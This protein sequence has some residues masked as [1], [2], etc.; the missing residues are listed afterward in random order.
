[1]SCNNSGCVSSSSLFKPTQKIIKFY[2]DSL[3]AVEGPKQVAK[4]DFCGLKIPYEYI[5]V[6]K[7]ILPKEVMSM[8][9]QH[10]LGNKL[11]FIALKLTYQPVVN[12]PQTSNCGCGCTS[13]GGVT[14]DQIIQYYFED[15]PDV[16]RHANNILILSGT[17]LNPLVPIYISNPGTKYNVMV[18]ILASAHEIDYNTLTHVDQSQFAFENM[19]WTDIISDTQSKDL[20]IYQGADPV[21]Y[22]STSKISNIELNSRVLIVDD[23]GAGAVYL[24]FADEFNAQQ[25]YSLIS[26]VLQN[27]AVN[28]I[29]SGMQAD[30]TAPVVTYKPFT[31]ELVLGDYPEDS[32]FLI[33]K[34]DLISIMIDSCYDS[35]DGAITVGEYN[36]NIMPVNTTTKYS[37]ISNMGKYNI[38]V[39]VSDNAGNISVESFLFNIK[40]T[41]PAK[42][43]LNEF[44][45]DIVQNV[46][47]YSDGTSGVADTQNKIWL[48]DYPHNKLT[49]QNVIDLLLA[50]VTD[51]RDGLIP[52]NINN[53]N[54]SITAHNSNVIYNEI[55]AEGVYDIYFNVTDA[56]NNSATALW[57][58]T[59]TQA[60]NPYGYAPLDY[61]R[62]EI[63]NNQAPE[64]VFKSFGVLGLYDYTSTGT[65]NKTEIIDFTV[66]HI[67]DD[68]DGNTTV[69][70]QSPKF[71]VAIFK[72][73]EVSSGT[74]GGYTSITPVE[75][76]YIAEPG[77][78]Q[79]QYT[80][81]DNDGAV[82]VETTNV[83][84]Q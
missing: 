23:F 34:S 75:V 58:N 45:I 17:K 66:D 44:G 35:R 70:S 49:K 47:P 51:A 69:S 16:V 72:T 11:T 40:D 18:D 33:E 9:V 84:V 31:P 3:V 52:M 46:M 54:V 13:C 67:T 83:T 61:V 53:I 65:I 12:N 80:M 10:N 38:I 21:G 19:K 73:S 81:I 50:A 24:T 7:M 59:T 74:S 43:I 22:I 55:N 79:I 60:L 4:L 14:N 15:Q 56:D 41:T 77:I 36:I 1:M 37:A 28:V 62:L 8:P 6:S 30:V 42:M 29:V 63:T 5:T 25:A 68:R 27:P 20:V 48:Q 39:E 2:Q 32:G 26:W 82:G 76:L 64:L 71:A 57:T 78:Y